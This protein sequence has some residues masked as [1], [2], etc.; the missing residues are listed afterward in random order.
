MIDHNLSSVGLTRTEPVPAPRQEPKAP[1]NTPTNPTGIWGRF[2][3][4]GVPYV[5][6]LLFFLIPFVIVATVSLSE[7]TVA[8]PPDLPVI[9]WGRGGAGLW[10]AVQHWSLSNYSK[11]VDETLY[12]QVYLS[13]LRIAFIST[14]L[15]VLVGFP[16]AYAMARAP[17]SWQ[18]ILVMM[19]ILPFWTSYL[20]RA[21]AW[22]GILRTD[23]LLNQAL[24]SVGLINEPLLLLNTSSTVYIGVIYTYLPFMVLPLYSALE[25]LDTTLTEAAEDLGCPPWQTF[26]YVTVPLA[27]PG[28]IAGCLLVF[29]PVMGEFIIP[30]L[31][32]GSSTQMIGQILW[33]EFFSHRDW[34]IASVIAIVLLAVLIIPI[35]LFQ[36]H[37]TRRS[38]EET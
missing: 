14:L 8:V 27:K 23:G 36:R 5:W 28:L 21:Y 1:E 4:I 19:V 38:E 20:I 16:I 22:I 30:D 24:M 17:R 9:E 25:R 18:P 6:L 3:L 26:W 29:I 33:A 12:W 7:I 32:G 31:L 37:E 34:P 13:S 2:A 10:E 15:T 35:L 11:L